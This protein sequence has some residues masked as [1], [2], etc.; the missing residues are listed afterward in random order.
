MIP[1]ESS[2]W[3]EL[4]H[5]YGAASDIP[6]LLQQ[7]PTAAVGGDFRAEPW[8]SLWSALCHQDDVYTASYAAVPH[9]VAA[10]AARPAK[11][12]P[13]LLFFVAYIEICRH[14]PKAP[15]IPADI[16]SDYQAALHAAEALAVDALRLPISETDIRYLIGSIAALKGYP[17]LGGAIIDLEPE[18]VCPKCNAVFKV[19]AYDQQ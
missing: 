3:K 8:F 6:Q 16:E 17:L 2:R 12:R 14:R 4:E 5:A 1:L 18:M 7:V 15:S 13:S 11:D 9:V 10:A 19:P